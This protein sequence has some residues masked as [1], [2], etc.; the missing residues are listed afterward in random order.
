M[1]TEHVRRA[2]PLYVLSLEARAVIIG[3]WSLFEQTY[4]HQ[5][6]FMYNVVEG[7]VHDVLVNRLVKLAKEKVVR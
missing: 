2:V 5:L 7:L 4:L 3:K 6:I 1:I